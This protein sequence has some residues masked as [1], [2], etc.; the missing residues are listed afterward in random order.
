MTLSF[1]EIAM[2]L[3]G[4]VEAARVQ[5]RAIDESTASATPAPGKWSKKEIL[6]HLMDS[7]ANNEQRLV[8]ARA[9]TELT[10]PPYD[11]NVW[12]QA[13]GYG[14]RGWS[15]L[16]QLWLLFNKD[17]VELLRL[18]PQ[19]VAEVPVHIGDNTMT[20]G[21]LAEDYVRHMVHHLHQIGCVMLPYEEQVTA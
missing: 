11:Q 7:C 9:V 6:G 2:R 14:Q 5:L 19:S 10:F 4:I 18:T 1:L 15:D 13:H 8:R 17:M 3:D 21:S 12:V 16:R 20:L